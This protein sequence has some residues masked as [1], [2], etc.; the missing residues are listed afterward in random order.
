MIRWAERGGE[1][2]GQGGGEERGG[3]LILIIFDVMSSICD[4]RL[5]ARDVE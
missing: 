2:Q 3:Y 1:G 5:G 4:K